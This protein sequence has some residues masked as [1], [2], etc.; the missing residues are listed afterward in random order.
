MNFFNK[1]STNIQGYIFTIITMVIWGSFSLLSRVSAK[2]NIQI[3]DLLALRFAIAGLILLPILYYKKDYRFL[4]DYRS[5]ILA[6]V[7]SIGY[8]SLVY[9]GFYYSPVVH[10]VILLNGLFP[11]FAAIMAFVFLKQ[12][13]DKHTKISM[14]IISIT[15]AVMCFLILKVDYHFNIGDL[16]FIGSAICWASFSILL[17]KWTF[18]AWQAMVSL[19]IWSAILYLPVYFLFVTP[20]LAQVEW[21][22]LAIQTTFHSVIVVIVATL[23]YAKAVEKIGIFKAGTIANIAPFAAAILAVPLLNEPLNSVMICGLLGM[24]LGA[25]QPWRW[26]PASRA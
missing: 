25:L 12:P 18:T 9:S 15:F 3:W 1:L 13:F 21:H 7:G 11:I 26:L 4:F 24:A 23:T 20:K 8:C 2:W 6:L 22:H 17:R 10:G 14:T 5:V 19:A 16:F